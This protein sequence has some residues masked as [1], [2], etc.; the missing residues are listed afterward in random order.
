M[1]MQLATDFSD[2]LEELAH[3]GVEVVVVGGY[4]VAVHARPRATKDL[5]LLLGGSPE[6]LARAAVAL[7]RFGAP[8]NVVRAVR[9]MKDDEVVYLGQPPLRVDLLRAIDGLR[10][11]DVLA[12]AVS[13]RL[14]AR[15]VRVISLDDLIVNKRA[16]DRPQDRL[17][18]ALL[19]RVRAH[20]AARGPGHPRG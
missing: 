14:G 7:E 9:A 10:T 6:N 13:V 18:V 15:E 3:E 12:R 20:R 17:D 8:P 2:R 4:A 16:A 1:P 19:E 5:D 11:E